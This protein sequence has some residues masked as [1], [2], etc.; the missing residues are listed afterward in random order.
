[1]KK[2]L[3]IF[4]LFYIT[5]TAQN[6]DSLYVAQN[7]N[8]YEFQIPM[9]DGIK[10]FTAVYVPKDT[11]E[12][13]PI[14]ISRTPYSIDPYGIDSVA[15]ILGPSRKFTKEKFI[16]VY[17][18]VRGRFMSEGE[19][20]DVRPNKKDENQIDESRDTY[21]TIEWLLKN[22]K[23]HNG[24]VG[25][26]GISYPGFYTSAVSID[27]HP[28]LVA[29][30]PQAPIADW[31]I[32]D[33]FHHN[34]AFWL[35]HAFNFY[36]VFG[37]PRPNLTKHWGKGFEHKTPDGYKFFLELGSL[38]NANKK[39]FHNEIK[40]WNDVMHHG[41]YDEFWQERNIL[42][43]L[44]NIKPAVLVV[45]GWFDAE[46]LY[47]AL[48]TYK[49]IEKENP[50]TKNNL[51]MGPWF[52]GGW[53]RSS[54]EMLGAIDFGSPTSLYYQDSI[55]F[56]FFN[57][58]LKGKGNLY[59]AEANVF[60]TGSNEWRK[61]ESWPPV[62]IENKNIYLNEKSKLTFANSAKKNSFNEYISDPNKPVPFTQEIT[63][64]MTHEYMVEDQRFASR[65][66]DVLVYESEILNDEITVAGQITADLFIST[67]GT[68][69]DFVVKIIDVFPDT[70]E[71]EGEVKYGGYQMMV[72][73]DVMRAKFRNSFEN[74]ESLIPNKVTEIK[75][76]LNDINHTFKKGHRI[77]VQIQSSWFPLVDRN[78]QKFVDIYNAKDE[79]FTKQ[80][81]RVYHSKEFPSHLVLP[82]L[83]K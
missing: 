22:L 52:H 68:D 2:L 26:W 48:N 47:G 21:D 55:E 41:T 6:P 39:Y 80:T 7:Y 4:I 82:I 53:A 50:H 43:H 67:T 83:K 63:T 70:L 60:E 56:P 75:F 34:G 29:V 78:P 46:N 42:N 66:T 24:K 17:Q 28:N 37:K 25:M 14:M 71:S 19:F 61:Y 74:P 8:K 44:K 13:Y 72:R 38:A 9:R 11:S 59:L 76:K 69:A 15:F 65:R 45:G 27:A 62:N 57:F 40:F 79:D 73:G 5:T 23:Y 64:R 12:K 10:L 20:V 35:P 58:Y 36:A 49:T 33:D 32:G 31:F 16:F 3:I 30:S 51:V 54:G 77:M 81:H 1:M 18:D